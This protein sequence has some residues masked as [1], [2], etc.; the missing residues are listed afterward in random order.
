MVPALK[1][2]PMGVMM[3]MDID[4]FPF[5]EIWEGKTWVNNH[6]YWIAMVI[7]VQ[8]AAAKH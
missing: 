1:L 3:L 6:Q 5:R 4:S 2:P 7:V 8:S